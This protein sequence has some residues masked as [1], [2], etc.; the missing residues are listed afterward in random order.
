M[1]KLKHVG[2]TIQATRQGG[3]DGHSYGLSSEGRD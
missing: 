3:G 2:T 1:G